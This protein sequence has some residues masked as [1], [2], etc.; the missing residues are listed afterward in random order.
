[1]PKEPERGVGGRAADAYG[2]CETGT[3]RKRNYLQWSNE[4]IKGTGEER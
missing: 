3:D 4:L 2:L 1:M